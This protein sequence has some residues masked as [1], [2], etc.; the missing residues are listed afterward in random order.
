MIHRALGAFPSQSWQYCG[1]IA[2]RA[3]IFVYVAAARTT[4]AA[5]RRPANLKYPLVYIVA[6]QRERYSRCGGSLPSRIGRDR[7]IS[8]LLS[9]GRVAN[10]RISLLESRIMRRKAR[11]LGIQTLGRRARRFLAAESPRIRMR[12]TVDRDGRAG[13][14]RLA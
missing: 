8:N 9:L 3:K 2:I 1:E 12:T 5:L 13:L 11:K 7:C 6:S 10:E 14:A 4:N